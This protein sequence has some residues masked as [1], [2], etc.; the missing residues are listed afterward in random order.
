MPDSSRTRSPEARL[1]IECA[2][3]QRTPASDNA[4]CAPLGAR[5][6][7]GLFL[8]LAEDHGLRPM[9]H[10]HLASQSGNPPRDV[11]VTLW[12]AQEMCARKNAAL[13]CELA[14][15][16]NALEDAGVPALP[17][18]GPLLAH[19]LYGDVALREFG[20]LDILV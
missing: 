12:A 19:A 20:D 5:I 15:V 6:D 16:V 4:P 13:T 14:R 1:L 7:W 9:A 17:Y 8:S 11:L 2:R 10:R 3:L 18:K